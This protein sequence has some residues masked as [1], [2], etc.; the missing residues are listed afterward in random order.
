MNIPESEKK[1][2]ADFKITIPKLSEWKTLG[3]SGTPVGFFVENG[4]ITK[5]NLIDLKLTEL[6]DSMGDLKELRILDL[7]CNLLKK[8]PE[9][10]QNLSNLREFYLG[11]NQFTS[12]P[13]WFDNL[14]NLRILSLINIKL[15]SIPESIGGLEYLEKISLRNNE[16]PVLPESFRNLKSLVYIDLYDTGLRSF[17]NIPKEIID[18]PDTFGMIWSDFSYY[19][20][21]SPQAKDLISSHLYGFWEFYRLSPI[22]LAQKYAKDQDSLTPVEKDRLAWEGGFRERNVLEMGGINPDDPILAEINKYLTI[23]YHNGLVL[24]K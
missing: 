21:P 12:L 13:E 4:H 5:L 22:E 14:R 3:R 24:L 2:L 1:V 20:D 11:A 15:H 23:M 8:L 9:S 18:Q 17:S 19:N 10:F 7:R 16:I 6:P